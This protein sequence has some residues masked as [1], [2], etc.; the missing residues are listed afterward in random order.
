MHTRGDRVPQSI[1]H[2]PFQHDRRPKRFQADGRTRVRR[3]TERRSRDNP[4]AHVQHRH[5]LDTT[6][7]LR[8]HV[9]VW[10]GD[11]LPNRVTHLIKRQRA[12]RWRQS[13]QRDQ[14]VLLHGRVKSL[15]KEGRQSK[16]F[17]RVHTRP[18]L[19][20]PPTCRLLFLLMSS[21]RQKVHLQNGFR[22]H[23]IFPFKK[24]T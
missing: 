21:Q 11:R 1:R 12:A 18:P 6:I 5:R 24:C 2:G 16:H 13:C 17:H 22:F 3:E 19:A 23:V 4:R 7:R 15:A 20:R 10:K 14:I 9:C 8:R